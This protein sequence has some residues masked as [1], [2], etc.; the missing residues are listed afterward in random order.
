MK[1]VGKR[2]CVSRYEE[3]IENIHKAG[4][5]IWGSFLFGTDNDRPGVFEDTL[6]FVMDNGIYSGSFT[7]LTPLP[8]TALFE[9]MKRQGRI[10]DEDWSRYTFWDVVYRPKHMTADQLA[11][12][13]A[14]VYDRFCI[15]GRSPKSGWPTS[16][17]GCVDKTRRTETCGY[18]C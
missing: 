10:L 16:A 14:Y 15:G 1:T 3:L 18:A 7:I 12:G 9:Q 8:G 13:V 2:R 5:Y 4:V 6:R 11:Q 17:A